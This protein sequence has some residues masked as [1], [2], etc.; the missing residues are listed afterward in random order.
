LVHAPILESLGKFVLDLTPAHVGSF[1]V[2][3][4]NLDEAIQQKN[5]NLVTCGGQATI[6]VAYELARLVPDIEYL[7]IAATIAS[8]SAGTGTRNNI[9]EFTQTT[10]DAL[11]F[12]TGIKRTKA[13]IVL[14][15]AEPPLI[16]HNTV[17]A[18]MNNPDM[19]QITEAVRRTEETVRA[20]VPGYKIILGPLYENGRLSIMVQVTGVGDYLP[21]YA[22]NLDIITC[23]A[24]KIAETWAER[25]GGHKGK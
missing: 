1:C 7:E 25:N 11:A 16:M 21:Q 10:K 6:P 5:V 20:Y 4:I 9:D 19:G 24:I 3:T 12:F 8:R 15:P 13:I 23:A 14:N 18:L 2:P 22:G 17:Y